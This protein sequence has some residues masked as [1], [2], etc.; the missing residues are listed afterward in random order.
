VH[1]NTAPAAPPEGAP[2][3]GNE[4]HHADGRV[5]LVD[6]AR[7][8]RSPLHNHDLAPVP[9]ARRNWSTYNYAA[10]WVSM[11]HCIPTYM[12]ASGL[13]ASGMNWWQALI[14]IL[15]GNTIVLVPILLNSHPGTKYGIPFPVFARAAYGTF[16]S[17]LPAIM[18]ALVACGWF[19]IQSWI[20]GE[21]LHTLFS[22]LL[23]SWP[24]LL[25]AGFGGHT[26]TEWLS[27]LL[28]WGGNIFIIYRGMDLLRHVE[29]WAAPFVLVMTAVLVWWAV[30]RADGLGPLL[31]GPGKFH[32][33]GEFLPVFIPSLTAMIGYWATLSLNMP[34]FTRFGRSQREQT[35]GQV[36]ALPTTMTVFAAMGVLI[37]SA[38]VIIYG[39]AIWDPIKLVGRFS[40]PVVIAIS[41]FTAVVATLAVNIAANVVSPAN[42]FANAFPRRIDFKTGGLITGILG[43]VMQPW[44]LLA[45]PS[46]YIYGWL[47]GYSGGLA[48]IAGVLIADYWVVKKKQLRLEDLYLTEGAYRY[49][50]GWNPAAVVAT[51]LGSAL[52]LVG[53]FVPALKPLFDYAWFVGFGVA[54]LVYVVLMRGTP[55][56]AAQAASLAVAVILLAS[57][58]EAASSKR[59]A[60]TR[61]AGRTV[62]PQAAELGRI[63]TAYVK[64]V[65]AGDLAAANDFLSEG[66]R[67]E[68]GHLSAKAA[69]SELDILSPLDDLRPYDA[70]VEGDEAVLLMGARVGENDATG[71][72]GMVREGG[73]WKVFSVMYNLG[74]APDAS[75]F[76][77]A[78]RPLGLTDAQRAAWRRLQEKGYPRPGAD[79]MIMTAGQGD[80]ELVKL[81]LEAGFKIEARDQGQTALGAAVRGGKAE[82]A[83]FLISAGA[84]T[85][86]VDDAGNTLLIH[87]ASGCGMTE[88]LRVLLAGGAPISPRNAAGLDALEMARAY[89][90][91][92]NAAMLEAAAA[93]RP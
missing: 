36:V 20:G 45:D 50:R 12:L 56:A 87:A 8:E 16:G 62:S 17:N 65:Q 58:A 2:V 53:W 89:Q 25:G 82:V 70:R 52:A 40:S 79:F 55:A 13:M 68:L 49:Q 4:R 66:K 74:A 29:N 39:E 42:D 35:L 6:S 5:E 43:L 51:V 24:T 67:R 60:V 19:G 90:C 78:A 28:F 26:T 64:A 73:Q 88:V 22:S 48:S 85:S 11:A 18:R 31:A 34:D 9:V 86:L 7:V 93:K 27:F 37:T 76:A 33:L 10:L 92:A 61:D 32:T 47:V 77:E 54:F 41:M 91:E 84:D 80:L 21:A 72:V 46:G 3:V 57:P 23:P 75:A 30:D 15:L 71:T 81:F 69:L 44:K 63:Y 38:T 83:L 1:D 14:T 59:K